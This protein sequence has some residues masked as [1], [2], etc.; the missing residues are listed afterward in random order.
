MLIWG[1]SVAVLLEVRSVSCLTDGII[2]GIRK[3]GHMLVYGRIKIL[4]LHGGVRR[5]CR[6]MIMDLSCRCY[7]RQCG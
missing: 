1:Y 7:G 4:C 3:V 2:V 6:M 5:K